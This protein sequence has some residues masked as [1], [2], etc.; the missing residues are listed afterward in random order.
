MS[1]AIPVSPA[2]RPA[3]V[4]QARGLRWAPAGSPVL[5]LDGLQIPPGV[6][7]V[8]GG[9][10]RGKSSLLRCLAG[11]LML[12]GSHLQIG[13]TVLSTEPAAYRAQV[14]WMDPRTTAHDQVRVLDFLAR[15]AQRYPAWNAALL[16]DLTEA[17]DL[18]PHLEKPLYML[19]TGSKRKVWLA[20][21]L[22][23]GAALT[24]LDEPFAALDKSSIR[25]VQD[26][27][28][29]AASHPQR[30]WVVADYEA[31]PGVPLA[32]HIDLGD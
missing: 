12:P 18:T 2:N 26:L 23:S 16:A 24:L 25:C 30:A 5:N 31:P 20:A 27:L 3:P 9:E 19:S 32:Q 13:R 28:R 10:G 8:G 29:E 11:E 7:W 14:F 21:A 1:L 15:T 4:A 22:A 6:S 17:L